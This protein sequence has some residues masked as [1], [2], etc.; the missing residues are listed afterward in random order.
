MVRVAVIGEVIA[1]LVACRVVAAAGHDFVVFFQ[2]EDGIRDH[3]VTG[4]QTCA[5]PIWRIHTMQQR[6]RWEELA[7]PTHGRV[8]PK[9]GWRGSTTVTVSSGA[10]MM[11]SIGV[12]SWS[13]FAD[14]R[15]AEEHDVGLGLHK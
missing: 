7:M 10:G 8:R 5:L 14:A 4:V 1:V 13:G 11:S 9:S 3:C 6:P 12:V 15:R 2:A